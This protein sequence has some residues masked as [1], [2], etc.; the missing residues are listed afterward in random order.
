MIVIELE[1][2]CNYRCNYCQNWVGLKLLNWPDLLI[3][4]LHKWNKIN[5]RV[6]L[7]QPNQEILIGPMI[8]IGLECSCN[9]RFNYSQNW[10]GL[11]SVTCSYIHCISDTKFITFDWYGYICSQ[12][13]SQ[14]PTYLDCNVPSFTSY[15]T[16][17]ISLGLD[18]NFQHLS[19]NIAIHASVC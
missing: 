10:A 11:E 19:G 12:C 15:R 8:V 14:F 5:K 3:H 6:T 1:C 2:S 16:L 13:C 4:S 18:F 17:T 7:S 9:Y